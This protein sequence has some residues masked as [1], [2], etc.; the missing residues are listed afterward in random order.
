MASSEHP[1]GSLWMTE[2]HYPKIDTHYYWFLHRGSDRRAV[3]P[4]CR[5]HK[6]SIRGEYCVHCRGFFCND[7]VVRD[8]DEPH[9][10]YCH[11]CMTY[12]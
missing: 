5:K 2:I 1:W 10:F 6:H 12:G 11:W 4:G 7:C 8:P 3:C 9:D